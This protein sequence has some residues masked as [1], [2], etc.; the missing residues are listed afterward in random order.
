MLSLSL[1]LAVKVNVYD[2]NILDAPKYENTLG[3]E[4]RILLVSPQWAYS[5]PAHRFHR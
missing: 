1:L 4:A 2:H 5:M 3:G